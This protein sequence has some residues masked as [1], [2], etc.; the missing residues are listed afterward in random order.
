V[1]A[2]LSAL[3][4][5]MVIT[6][7]LVIGII[8]STLAG[9]ERPTPDT[10]Q[11][12]YRGVA[13]GLVY[14]PDKLEALQAANQIPAALPQLPAT[15][16]RA[17]DS[18]KNVKVLGDLST[19]EFIRT[20]L[21]M[22]AWVA[23]K[24]G[25]AYCH[26]TADMASDALYSKVVARRMLEMTRH[27]NSQWKTHVAA[28]GV[29]CYTCHR[30]EPVPANIW[31]TNPGIETAAGEFGDSG[32]KNLPAPQIGLTSLPYDPFSTFL[33][34]DTA[35]RVVSKTALPDGDD[36]SIKQTEWT[37][38]LMMHMSQSL[39]VNCTYCHNSRSFASWDLSPPT[40][41]TAW[42][43]IRMV[44]DLN[45]GYL[46]PLSSVFPANRHG[47]LGD[48]PK[49]NC[50]TCHQGVYKPLFGASMLKDYPQF[51][52]PASSPSEEKPVAPLQAAPSSSSKND[53][54]K[55]VSDKPS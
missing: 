33:D 11:R 35:I 40:R 37:Y 50:A 43:G 25:C 17:S 42:Y 38:A 55:V 13:M 36:K 23:P 49:L 31:F 24:Q 2:R 15:G 30:G 18:Y 20:M 27:I 14:N 34:S 22:T 26:N 39:G 7:A 5:G 46:D 53:S 8:V 29:T 16:P 32:G 28:T 45:Q 6:Y 41:T 19:G 47:P 9:C 44:R 10:I 12:G 4:Y 3:L 21:A 52:E 48:G 51:A 54:T 1:N